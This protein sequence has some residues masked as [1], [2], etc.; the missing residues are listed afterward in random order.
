MDWFLYDRDLRQERVKDIKIF[1][2]A[3]IKLSQYKRFALK[4]VNYIDLIL[5][6]KLTIIFVFLQYGQDRLNRQ[7]GG[8]LGTN[9]LTMLKLK[10]HLSGGFSLDVSVFSFSL[11]RLFFVFVEHV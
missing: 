7:L 3:E 1:N 5:L 8:A 10:Q 11:L 9:G 6:N 4:I 2:Y